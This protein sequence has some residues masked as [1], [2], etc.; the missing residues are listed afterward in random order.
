ML[1]AHIGLGKTATSTLQHYIFP[2]VAKLRPGLIYNEKSTYRLLRK[3]YFFGL[4]NDERQYLKDAFQRGDHFVSKE[5]LA[6]TNP[7]YWETSADRNL[8]LFGADARIVITVREPVSYLTS[9]YQQMIQSGRVKPPDRFFVRGDL[10]NRLRINITPNV[11]EFFDVDSFD[12]ERLEAIYRLRFASVT[13]APLSTMNN[14]EFLRPI[15]DLKDAE[16]ERLRQIFK[17]APPQNRAFSNMGMRLTF[18][19]ESFANKL[20]YRTLAKRDRD[21]IEFYR[22]LSDPE[23]SRD[24]LG[25]LPPAADRSGR[26]VDMSQDIDL[27]KKTMRW[28]NFIRKV[29]DRIVPYEKYELPSSIDLNQAMVE[30]NRAYIGRLEKAHA[31]ATDG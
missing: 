15:F 6:N 4:D 13:V 14:M 23:V 21:R 24:A 10:Y 31:P 2:A 19:R 22:Y 26:N 3:S 11:L 7:H 18:M 8:D 25:S 17:N 30:K 28:R 27:S 16:V 1:V 29:V 12:L 9:V 5:T 20:G